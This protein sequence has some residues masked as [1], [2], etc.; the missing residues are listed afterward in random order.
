MTPRIRFLL[1]LGGVLIAATLALF[2]W[3]RRD[4]FTEIGRAHV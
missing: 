3:L 1:V 4:E 2:A